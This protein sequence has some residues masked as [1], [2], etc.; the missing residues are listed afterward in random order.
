M[1]LSAEIPAPVITRRRSVCS[2]TTEQADNAFTLIFSAKV[3]ASNFISSLI[4]TIDI[5]DNLP[6]HFKDELASSQNAAA[7]TQSRR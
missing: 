5:M 2:R 1:P 3:G 7:D 6:P 4:I